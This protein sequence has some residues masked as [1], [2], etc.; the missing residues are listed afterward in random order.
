MR[1]KYEPTRLEKYLV[2]GAEEDLEGGSP[3]SSFVHTCIIQAFPST[4]K[5]KCIIHSFPGTKESSTSSWARSR[6]WKGQSMALSKAVRCEGVGA[7][8]R[9]LRIS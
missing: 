8:N 7:T 4:K 3:R 1:L 2:L 9:G 6:I 5:P